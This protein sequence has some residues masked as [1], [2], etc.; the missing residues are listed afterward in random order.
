MKKVMAVI[1]LLLSF[2]VA[3]YANATII[4]GLEITS[5]ADSL[6][7]S[8]GTF[9][10]SGAT[11]AAV[12]TDQDPATYAGSWDSGAYVVLGF[13][14]PIVNGAG[15]DLAL[16]E[17]GRTDTFKLSLSLVGTTIN[18]PSYYTGTS[19]PPGFN[20]NVATI[21]LADFGVA[22][23]GTVNQIVVGLDFLTEYTYNNI[24]YQTVPTL[25]LAGALNSVPVP[26]AIWLL[27]SGLVGL[28]GWR[29]LKKG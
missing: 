7:S 6:I 13:S 18:Y 22:P 10:T 12:L 27:G 14:S 23:G 16:F 26:G 20:L 2:F 1:A 19:V 29:R 3:G 17:L 21:D 15:A 24:I 4:G 8:Y 9:D 25:S 28:L 11:L 5:F